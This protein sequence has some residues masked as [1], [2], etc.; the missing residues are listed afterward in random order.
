M[1]ELPAYRAAVK[2]TGKQQFFHGH[3]HFETK[4][5]LWISDQDASRLDPAKKMPGWGKNGERWLDVNVSKQTLVAYE[6]EKPVFATL[7]STG[8]AG[9]QDHEKPPRRSAGSFEF[10]RSMFRPRWRPTKSEK[11]SNCVTSRTSNISKTV[12]PFTVLTGTIASVPRRATVV[13]TLRRKM[14][15][16][17]SSSL[18]RSCLTVG[19]AFSSR[20]PEPSSSFIH[21]LKDSLSARKFSRRRPPLLPAAEAPPCPPAGEPAEPCFSAGATG[22][23]LPARTRDAA[24][25]SCLGIRRT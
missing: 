13:S 22:T 25:T 21:E 11:N 8:E 3:L 17:F 15:G 5:G 18:S 14:L 12:T 20:S 23:G 16:G 10:I 1:R 24:C 6:G 19:T 7:V 4:D 2:L 9:L